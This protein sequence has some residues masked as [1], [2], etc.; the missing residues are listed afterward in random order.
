ML[1]VFVGGFFYVQ[2]SNVQWFVF[3]EVFKVEWLDMLVYGNRHPKKRQNSIM[4]RLRP[5]FM[6]S[7]F[8]CNEEGYCLL[9]P[10][11][12]WFPH[13]LI[14]PKPQISTRKWTRKKV[15]TMIAIY[16]FDSKFL[17][18]QS[19]NHTG[20]RQWDQCRSRCS[21]RLHYC[22]HLYLEKKFNMKN[23]KFEETPKMNWHQIRLVYKL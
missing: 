12:F 19:D 7:F 1:A 14:T 23:E 21:D 8:I 13:I 17:W 15:F 2:L 3:V 10:C 20:R 22:S 11:N 5:L 9:W 4:F 16:Q 18:T 6:W